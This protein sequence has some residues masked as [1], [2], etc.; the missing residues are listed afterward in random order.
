[1]HSVSAY[2]I[3]KEIV[4]LKIYFFIYI[5]MYCKNAVTVSH[6]L[7]LRVYGSYAI[8]PENPVNES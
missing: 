1:M 2:D 7:K 8:E 6:K 5:G 4:I 3:Y